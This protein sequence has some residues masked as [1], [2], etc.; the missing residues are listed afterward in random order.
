MRSF[1]LLPSDCE[2]GISSVDC[3]IWVLYSSHVSST[4]SSIQQFHSSTTSQTHDRVHCSSLANMTPPSQTKELEADIA[5]TA[6]TQ[7]QLNHAGEIISALLSSDSADRAASI[8][9]QEAYNHIITP[10]LTINGKVILGTAVCQAA[11]LAG[12]YRFMANCANK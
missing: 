8:L 10:C 5:D 6:R 11:K 1:R 7:L 12:I 2:R 3:C 9:K 4:Y